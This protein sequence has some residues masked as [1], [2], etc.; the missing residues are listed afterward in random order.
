MEQRK[1]KTMCVFFEIT[2]WQTLRKK[3]GVSRKSGGAAL[4]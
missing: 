1:A 4:P 3:H 2:H